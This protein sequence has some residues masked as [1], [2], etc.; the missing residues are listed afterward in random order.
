MDTRSR[1]TGAGQAVIRQMAEAMWE[2][3]PNH[4][5]GAV[6]KMLV[7]PENSDSRLLDFRISSYQ[8]A[9][10]ARAHS[11]R[12]QEQIYYVLEGEGLIEIDGERTLVGPH[13]T[14]FL[15]PGVEHAIYNSGTTDLVF[16]VVTTPPS[17]D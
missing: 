12:K 13:T 11:H 14:I 3:V 17:D 6:S 16:L 9:A 10:H 7:R 1:R 15:P 5:P 2:A 4:A 8:P